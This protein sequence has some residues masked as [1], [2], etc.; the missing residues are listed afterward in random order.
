MKKLLLLL[1]ILTGCTYIQPIP[2]NETIPEVIQE[3]EVTIPEE[4]EIEYYHW[5]DMP[6]TYYI[7]NEDKCG[8]YESRKIIRAF[9]EI[10]D[11]TDGIVSFEKIDQP[12]NIDIT[13]SFIEDCY[14]VTVDIRREEGVIYH[15]E[16]ICAHKLG[17]ARITKRQGFEIL[18]AEIKLIGLGGFAETKGTGTSGFYIGTCGHN[19][20]EIHE[21][22]HTFGYSHINN[23]KSIMYQ[24]E[25]GV[26]L[27]IQK[28]GA[29]TGNKKII[30]EEI[31]EGLVE[32][33][34]L[35]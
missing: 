18:K 15:Y 10:S 13:C 3:P 32:V 1:L 24:S 31:V 28:E 6:I 20:V 27:T 7:V 23:T 16:T 22:L 21:I 8:D 4:P 14:K 35:I 29:C 25:E 17:E 12:A 2:Q 33:Y 34:S 11:T 30:D 19:N 5:K 9:D 26:G